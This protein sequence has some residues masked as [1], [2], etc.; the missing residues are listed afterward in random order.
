[1]KYQSSNFSVSLNYKTIAKNLFYKLNLD[2]RP[3]VVVASGKLHLCWT[4]KAQCFC[5]RR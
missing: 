4:N 1:M 2:I 3:T 5:D